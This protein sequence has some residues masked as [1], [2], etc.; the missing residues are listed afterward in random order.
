MSV[1]F[2]ELHFDNSGCSLSKSSSTAAI[3]ANNILTGL[4]DATW[5][6]L[7]L[8][9]N[10]VQIGR[11]RCYQTGYDSRTGT[12]KGLTADVNVSLLVSDEAD[13]RWGSTPYR[14]W[15]L[16]VPCI[17]HLG[18]FV[19]QHLVRIPYQHHDELPRLPSMLSRCQKHDSVYGKRGKKQNQSSVILRGHVRIK[20]DGR[21]GACRAAVQCNGTYPIYPLT[22]RTEMTKATRKEAPN[23]LTAD[24]CNK[25]DQ[26]RRG[27]SGNIRNHATD[28]PWLGNS[29]VWTVGRR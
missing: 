23:V 8:A 7:S 3:V 12:R 21:K 1:P 27:H 2:G 16:A 28:S 10:E 26:C 17:S 9:L 25:W 24:S 18:H 6:H 29:L 13:Q 4:P 20:E 11:Q 14:E 15:E 19:S 5:N 22:C